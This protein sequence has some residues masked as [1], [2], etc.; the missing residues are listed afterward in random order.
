[1]KILF[2]SH[3]ASRTGAPF[4]LLYL[5]QWLKKNS[6][7]EVDVLLLKNGQLNEEFKSVAGRFYSAADILKEESLLY[8]IKRKIKWRHELF[9]H[10]KKV[11]RQV[12]F[13]NYDLVYG[14]T[15]LT[16]GWLHEIKQLSQVKT[17]AAIHEMKHSMLWFYE[18]EELVEKL[19]KLDFIIAGSEAVST[20]LK[21][22]FHV[23]PAVLETVH[24]F[25]NVPDFTPA[26][27]SILKGTAIDPQ[28]K[29]FI[30]GCAGTTNWRKGTDLAILLALYLKKNHPAFH[31]H[32]LWIGGDK[33][34]YINDLKYD[35]EKAGLSE[36]I[37]FVGSTP[38][39]LKYIRCFDVFAMLSRE[40]PFPLVSLEAAAYKVPIVTFSDAGGT[41]E[42]INGQGGIVV[43]YLDIMAF[44]EA[45]KSLADHATRRQQ[46]GE[47]LRS[48]VQSKYTNEAMGAKI[49][50]ILNNRL[51]DQSTIK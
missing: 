44:G 21:K 28:N 36:H 19:N 32:L 51:K 7:H 23:V 30:I 8:R 45:I 34:S 31:F 38:D 49:L 22:N 9:R 48:E 35:I 15:T 26:D 16:L 42:L 47:F 11:N 39:Y 10:V 46:M 37:S 25:I 12:N 13:E 3:E 4:V 33:G 6:D 40:D 29:G 1:L 20:D 5:L 17:I 2:I 14:N 27:Y 18:K 43:P 24:A 50:S 41:A